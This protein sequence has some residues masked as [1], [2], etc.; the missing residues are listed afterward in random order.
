M[1]LRSVNRAYARWAPIYDQT[2]GAIT[3]AGRKRIA[4]LANEM[5]GSLLEVGVGTGMS[6]GLYDETLRIT[7]IDAS[8]DMLE[9]ARKKVQEKQLVNVESLTEMD[10]RELA[11]ADNSFDHV[12]ASH[13]M[14]VVPEPERVVAELARVC[15]PGGIVYIANHFAR[16]KGFLSVVEKAAAPLDKLLGWHSDF[17][18]SVVTGCP[19]LRLVSEEDLRPLGI[20]TLLRF[21][22]IAA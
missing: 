22:K 6:L 3:S 12:A 17:Q 18:R 16:D 10:A 11:F 2:F 1:E 15:K 7:G 14:S 4:T 9:Q 20:M 21:E 5:G 13:I 19:E 8:L